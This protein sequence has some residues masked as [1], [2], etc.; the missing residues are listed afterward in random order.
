[1]A[2]FSIVLPVYNREKVI[3]K[4]VQS[5]LNQS[6]F[7][8]E[9]LIVDDCSTDSTINE[10]QKY[11]DSRIRL[12]R[13]SINSG[14]AVSRNWGIKVSKGEVICFL[15][16]DD[17]YYPDFLTRSKELLDASRDNIGFTWTGLEVK[18]RDS[19]KIEV[20][21][22]EINES[23]YYTFLH[24]LRIGTNSGLSIRRRVFEECGLFNENLTAAED[25]EF[26]LRIVRKFN[27]KV[28]KEPLIFIDKSRKDRLSLDYKKNAESYNWFIGQH[29]DYIVKYPELKR[30]FTYKLMW[31]N[32]HLADAEKARDYY[33]Q[34]KSS[35]GFS[36]K[37]FL[38]HL[39]FEVFG[40]QLGSRIH[41]L[42]SK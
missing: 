35:F 19:V 7:D 27:F 29:W 34:Y 14:P 37:V 13:N 38:V 11:R 16:S 2:F 3:S 9:L 30:K 23:P 20:W 18:Y 17:S 6:Y 25:T 22:P 1:M 31:L 28:L 15:D 33:N 21:E 4:A 32:Y 42:L 8:W 5:V 36:R 39:I 41:V 26:L 40:S 10:I 24:T 12:F